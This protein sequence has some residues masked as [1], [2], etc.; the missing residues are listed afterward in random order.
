MLAICI[1]ACDCKRKQICEKKQATIIVRFTLERRWGTYFDSNH[2]L[3]S[4][5]DLN[6]I[7]TIL[8]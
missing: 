6:V 1:I 3:H 2:E 4:A 8:P 7:P 5:I